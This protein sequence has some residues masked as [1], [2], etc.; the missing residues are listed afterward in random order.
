MQFA[1]LSTFG[2]ATTTLFL[3]GI[4]VQPAAISAGSSAFTVTGP[5]AV[6]R[7][8][9]FTNSYLVRFHR[10]VDTDEAHRIAIRNGFDNLGPV[11]VDIL[12]CIQIQ[13]KRIA[14]TR[15]A[16]IWTAKN[17]SHTHT[18]RVFFTVETRMIIGKCFKS[19]TEHLLKGCV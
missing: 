13:Q 5:A 17:N 1:W 7:N 4:L 6:R 16:L 11:S 14:P 2:L 8:D 12:I 9:V 3:V 15:D 10:S 18:N 19:Y